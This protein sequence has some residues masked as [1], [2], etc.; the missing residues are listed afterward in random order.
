MKEYRSNFIDFRRYIIANSLFTERQISIIYRRLTSKGLIENTSSGA[1]Y[2]QVK[3]CRDKIIGLIYSI[4]LLRSIGA[5][6]Q[7]TL[8]AIEKLADQLTVIL[9]RE[10]SDILQEEGMENVISVIEQL[11]KRMCKV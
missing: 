5:I 4:I 6:D 1:Y 8:L 10:N 3:Q 2:R 11:V 9:S 7:Q